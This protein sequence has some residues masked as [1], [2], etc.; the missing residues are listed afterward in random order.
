MKKRNIYNDNIKDIKSVNDLED[1]KESLSVLEKTKDSISFEFGCDFWKYDKKKGE[2]KQYNDFVSLQKD[3]GEIVFNSAKTEQTKE[4]GAVL[5]REINLNKNLNNLPYFKIAERREYII[6]PT[7]AVNN[8]FKIPLETLEKDKRRVQEITNKATKNFDTQETKP[9]LDGIKSIID[10]LALNYFLYKDFAIKKNKE[11]YIRKIV[12]GLDNNF[13]DINKILNDRDLIRR[14]PELKEVLDRYQEQNINVENPNNPFN[15][16]DLTEPHG[17]IELDDTILLEEYPK[18]IDHK[19][20]LTLAAEIAEK[21]SY[22]KELFSNIND[23]VINKLHSSLQNDLKEIFLD[24]KK[25][26]NIYEPIEFF[27]RDN[28]DEFKK[29]FSPREIG[30]AYLIISNQISPNKV[31][32]KIISEKVA[33]IRLKGNEGNKISIHNISKIIN[34]VVDLGLNNKPS[35]VIRL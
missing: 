9:F 15:F 35:R 25:N 4:Y 20:V 19:E 17:D 1:F 2:L 26:K 13:F 31:D 24:S 18:F 34:K 22:E 3:I 29:D 33:R 5:A 12:E 16:G 27:F 21:P 32:K 10:V 14:I 7:K 11:K 23:K 8:T 28:I 30:L 6:E